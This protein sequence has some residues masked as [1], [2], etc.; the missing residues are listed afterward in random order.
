ML[1]LRIVSSGGLSGLRGAGDSESGEGKSSSILKMK[2][3]AGE[4]TIAGETLP[5][6]DLE[7]ARVVGMRMGE[8]VELEVD[9][10]TGMPERLP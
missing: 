8:T 7:W 3:G 5:E 9:F 1:W 4:R 2:S 10:R 6:D